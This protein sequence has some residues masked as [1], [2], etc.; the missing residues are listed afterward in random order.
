MDGD[1]N[2]VQSPTATREDAMTRLADRANHVHE[3][4]EQN[5]FKASIRKIKEQVLP[6][7]LERVDPEAAA[8]LT[9]DE[10]SKEFRPII[11]EVLAD[12]KITFTTSRVEVVRQIEIEGDSRMVPRAR[13]LR[14]TRRAGS[15]RHQ[16]H[17]HHSPRGE[18]GAS[19]FPPHAQ[20]DR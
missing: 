15:I 5:G 13:H 12:L 19:G 9:K 1:D 17:L 3:S 18:M 8:T 6:R 11:V 16:P 20:G 14:A 10:L 2:M 4:N 7:L